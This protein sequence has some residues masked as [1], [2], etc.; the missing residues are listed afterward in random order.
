MR[1][2]AYN[3]SVF[4]YSGEAFLT[5]YAQRALGLSLGLSLGA[6]ASPV[7]DVNFLSSFTANIMTMLLIVA[8][9]LSMPLSAF[10]QSYGIC[11]V[12]IPI[13]FLLAGGFAMAVVIGGIAEGRRWIRLENPAVRRIFLFHS[14]RQVIQLAALIGIPDALLSLMRLIGFVGVALALI[15]GGFLQNTVG[16]NKIATLAS[17]I[18]GLFGCRGSFV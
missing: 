18:A 1:K 17:T 10:A 16:M 5:L 8:A 15:Q 6:A 4:S 14:V 3:F 13:G 11:A 2:R 9:C 12:S 7:K